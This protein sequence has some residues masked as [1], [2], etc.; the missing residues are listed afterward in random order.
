MLHLVLGGERGDDECWFRPL[1]SLYN[2]IKS[3]VSVF[4][5]VVKGLGDKK[6]GQTS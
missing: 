3:C 6:F 5:L 4:L 2:P 1:T